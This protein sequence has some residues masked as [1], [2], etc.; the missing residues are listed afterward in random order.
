MYWYGILI[1]AGMLCA[2]LTARAREKRCGFEEDLSAVCLLAGVPAGIVCA[3]LYYVAFSFDAYRGD[4]LSILDLRSG[5]LAI[6]G[7]VL[8]GL[9]ALWVLSRVK[10]LPFLRLCDLWAPG[11]ALA[12]AIWHWGNFANGEA[13]GVRVADESLCFFPLSVWIESDSSWH[14]ATFFY[15]SVWCLGI[16]VFLL[17]LERRGRRRDGDL[18]LGY[19]ALYAL[20]RL[21]VEGLRTDS[22]MWGPVR[23]SQALSAAVL[24][25]ALTAIC[26]RRRRR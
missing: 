2:Y 9:A 4:P 1:A 23:V 11:V 25:A 8:G 16:C 21:F 7:G 5:G 10:K 17:L 13:Y 26:I 18:F 19:A 6:Y 14:L 24:A 3:R 15:E 20:E 12:Q 22:L